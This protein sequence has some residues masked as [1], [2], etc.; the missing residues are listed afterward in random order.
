M[1]LK[2]INKRVIIFWLIFPLYV[3][4]LNPVLFA[5]PTLDYSKV[6]GMNETTTNRI[7][8][9]VF[10]SQEYGIVESITAYLNVTSHS[11]KV[12]CVIY[13]YSDLSLVASTEERVISPFEGWRTFNFTNDK[14]RLN[15]DTK[16]MLA[17][18]SEDDLYVYLDES[19]KGLGLNMNHTLYDNSAVLA[20]NFEEGP[21]DIIHD[22]SKYKNDGT[23]FGASWIDRNNGEAIK[24]DG[25]DNYIEVDDDTSL[26]FGSGDLTF[27][28]W[29]KTD[30]YCNDGTGMIWKGRNLGDF[31]FGFY[32]IKG[33]IS[34]RVRYHYL[35]YGDEALMD[36]RSG[37][38]DDGVWHHAVGVLV[39][40]TGDAYLYIDGKLVNHNEI[41]LWREEIKNDSPLV[42][43]SFID[44][45]AYFNGSIDDV[46]IYARA[47]PNSEVKQQYL[48]GILIPSYSKHQYPIYLTWSAFGLRNL[49][50]ASS[51][52]NYQA[53]PSL[54][55]FL[56]FLEGK[57]S[58]IFD[59]SGNGNHGIMSGNLSWYKGQGFY[60]NG[61][62]EYIAIP[63]DPS[64]VLT[65]DFTITAWLKGGSDIHRTGLITKQ[66]HPSHPGYSLTIESFNHVGIEFCDGNV[67]HFDGWSPPLNEENWYF[68]ALV[69]GKRELLTHF[70]KMYIN[71]TKIGSDSNLFHVVGNVTNNV[72][73][74]VANYGN[75]KENSWFHGFIREIRIYNRSLSDY[76]IRRLYSSSLDI[77]RL[78]PGSKYV[79]TGWVEQKN[80]SFSPLF[81]TTLQIYSNGTP[82]TSPDEHGMYRFT[83]ILPN[84]V[85]KYTNK[86]N[87]DDDNTKFDMPELYESVIADRISVSRFGG[88]D[89]FVGGMA[90]AWVQLIS[91]Y[92]GQI[93]ESGNVTFARGLTARWN[94]NELRWEIRL[95]REAGE[96]EGNF[97][98]HLEFVYW[99]KYGI[100]ALNPDTQKT[101]ITVRWIKPPWYIL[102]LNWLEKISLLIGGIIIIFFILAVNYYLRI[103]H[104][105]NK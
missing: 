99:D 94:P 25:V 1:K 75:L 15:K 13:Q 95:P 20:F 30:E 7:N 14:P 92:D 78:D 5:L 29:F 12:K 39:Q 79:T 51:P 16:Y 54:I 47:I 93:V 3:S 6:G 56:S 26:D 22:G 77:L 24:F 89:A 53:D 8:G 68:V 9:S 96:G 91:E 105:R 63:D 46:V 49:E 101:S 71:G 50:V 55:L 86:I 28:A 62:N 23:N 67:T 74:T 34:F 80:N 70:A 17:V 104:A 97:T 19:T 11:K 82:V 42:F 98:T 60:F 10:T 43:G 64:L 45:S 66:I 88:I 76:E 102:M 40:S 21:S 61:E 44:Y 31:Q 35:M 72:P 81:L 100:T 48:S 4:S 73:L 103:R 27:S 83:S 57:G 33:M 18:V 41:L 69:I 36:L 32:F 52:R 85:G 65:E 38:V 2:K 37:R 90:I 84:K 87:I 59:I 58:T